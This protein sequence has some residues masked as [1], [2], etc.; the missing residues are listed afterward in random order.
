MPFIHA[1][2]YTEEYRKINEKKTLK[3]QNNTSEE[4]KD[5]K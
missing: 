1:W 5:N 3:L 4:N 2:L